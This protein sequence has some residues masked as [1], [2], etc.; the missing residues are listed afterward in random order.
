MTNIGGD[1]KDK[2]TLH[3]LL[4]CPKTYLQTAPLC[5]IP[6]RRGCVFGHGKELIE[7]QARLERLDRQTFDISRPALN[8]KKGYTEKPQPTSPE[9]MKE[10]EEDLARPEPL[11]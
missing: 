1:R 4:I 7:T 2:V 5:G 11:Q 8:A 6:D 10:L 9:K 3:F